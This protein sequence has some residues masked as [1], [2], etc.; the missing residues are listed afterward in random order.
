[1]ARWRE[2]RDAAGDDFSTAT[3]WR[4]RQATDA[5]PGWRTGEP[6]PSEEWVEDD[7]GLGWEGVTATPA[8]L[9]ATATPTPTAAAT[10]DPAV[11]KARQAAVTRARR[12]FC[13]G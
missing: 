13:I 5:L 1:V 2:R 11:V 6:S 9:A 10:V 8:A 12:G 3:R 7:D 4:E